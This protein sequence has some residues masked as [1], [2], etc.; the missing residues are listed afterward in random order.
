MEESGGS[1]VKSLSLADDGFID[2]TDYAGKQIRSATAA[3][4]KKE[5]LRILR[6]RMGEQARAEAT[7]VKPQA[8][9]MTFE[10]FLD[11]VFLPHTRVTRRPSTAKTYQ[12]Y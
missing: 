6:A 12:A 7:G 11:E 10:K 5:A 8:L 9:T 4:T 3:S 2:Y 1:E